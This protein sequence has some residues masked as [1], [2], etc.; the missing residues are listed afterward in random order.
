MVIKLNNLS[1]T[2]LVITGVLFLP[3]LLTAATGDLNISGIATVGALPTAD[4]ENSAVCFD[5]QTG[6]LGKCPQATIPDR[7]VW[8]STIGGDYNSLASALSDKDTWCPSPSENAPC[9]IKV[10][11]GNYSSAYQIDMASHISIEGAGEGVTILQNTSVSHYNSVISANLVENASVSHLT[12]INHTID[13]TEEQIGISISGSSI[14][15]SNVTIDV[16]GGDEARGFYSN[17]SL[18]A[19]TT[20]PVL[21][22]VTIIAKNGKSWTKGIELSNICEAVIKNSSIDVSS[23]IGDVSGMRFT[24]AATP[25]LSHVSIRAEGTETVYGIYNYSEPKLMSHLT[26]KATGGSENS[27]LFNASSSPHKTYTID[28]SILTSDV[29]SLSIN[30]NTYFTLFIEHSTLSSVPDTD[31]TYICAGNYVRDTITPAYIALD[32]SCQK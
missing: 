16:S 27:A 13:D 28:Y 14:K 25:S 20:A 8:V 17:H 4:T 23:S 1:R 7:I 31:G 9:L 15:I 5:D 29:G 19:T 11:P 30:N 3:S 24:G 22:Q 6:K 12:I 21:N 26:I 32:S 18:A 10:A 2:I